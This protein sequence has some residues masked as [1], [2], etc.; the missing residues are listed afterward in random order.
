[1]PPYGDLEIDARPALDK[2]RIADGRQPPIHVAYLVAASP[3]HGDVGANQPAADHGH[4]DDDDLPPG[5]HLST[6][7]RASLRSGR[8]ILSTRFSTDV[9]FSSYPYEGDGADGIGFFI[10]ATDPTAPAPPEHDRLTAEGTLPR[11]H[12]A[13]GH[14]VR[15]P[16]LAFLLDRSAQR[17]GC[18][19]SIYSVPGHVRRGAAEA[20][21]GDED[22][23]ALCLG[24]FTRVGRRPASGGSPSPLR[25]SARLRSYGAC[26]VP[27]WQRSPPTRVRPRIE[28][29]ARRLVRHRPP[30]RATQ[31]WPTYLHDAARTSVS[32]DTTLT[33]AN[34]AFLQ[35]KFTAVTGGIIAAEPAIV[36][37]TAFTSVRGTAT[38]IALNTANWR[39]RL[40]ASS[41]A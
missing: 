34:V 33:P 22:K 16:G 29:R 5:C 1:M 37:Q 31:D 4:D 26:S 32:G 11:R 40:E 10:A 35:K 39:P 18:G 19:V 7:Y 13:G 36:G 15:R 24:A 41:S 30:R 6:G 23:G 2:T 28:R 14:R 27:P 38:S 17:S 25:A 8:T 3:A 20:L 9:P 12:P 21:A